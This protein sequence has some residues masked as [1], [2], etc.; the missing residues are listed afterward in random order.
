MK[1]FKTAGFNSE[2]ATKHAVIFSNNRI[3]PDMLPDLDKPSLKE[4]GITLMGDMIAI[5]RYAKKV[6]EKDTCDKFLVD[7]K[8]SPIPN[9]APAIKP[10]VKRAVTKV[11]AKSPVI[12]KSQV[13][14]PRVS[15]KIQSTVSVKPVV[16]KKTKPVVPSTARVITTAAEKEK[17]TSILKRKLDID[18]I[19]IG[20]DC[21]DKWESQKR[22]KV[23]SENDVGY[24]V[25][26]P[27]GLTAYRS[28]TVIKKSADPKRTV[29]ERLGDSSVT[30]TTSTSEGSA[31]TF[32]ITGLGKDV[33][34][35]NTNVFNRLGDKDSKDE[36]ISAG[37]LRNG[38]SPAS[39][40][41][42]KARLSTSRVTTTTPSAK[43]TVL[44]KVLTKAG[45]GTMRAD[46]EKQK[47]VSRGV[48]KLMTTSK[49]SELRVIRWHVLM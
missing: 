29:F 14:V 18:H 11:P 10:I 36:V 41:A 9:R 1:F 24:T 5:L 13:S 43:Q 23:Q 16:V 25:I 12:Q 26:M 33:V 40:N 8:D 38:V 47:G 20:S 42:L 4:M 17:P 15:S 35:R 48:K 32:N 19:D 27:K 39:Q 2:V 28:Q 7:T 46:F 3:Q 45:G 30:S 34:K 6:V 31:T 44:T 22:T 49:I 21:D 37:I